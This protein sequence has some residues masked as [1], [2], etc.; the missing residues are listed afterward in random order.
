MSWLFKMTFTRRMTYF[1]YQA[2]LDQALL[3]LQCH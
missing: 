2:V 3:Y 1:V